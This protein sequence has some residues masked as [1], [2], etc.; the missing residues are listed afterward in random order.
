MAQGT[1]KWFNSDKGYGE[2][3]RSVQHGR[4]WVLSRP[5]VQQ[6]RDWAVQEDYRQQA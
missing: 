2:F 6:W 4:F 1:V 5:E 3:N